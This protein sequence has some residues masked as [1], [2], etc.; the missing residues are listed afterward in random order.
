MYY[1]KI[2]LIHFIAIMIVL[3][4]TFFMGFYYYLVINHIYFL[5]TIIK[6]GKEVENMKE[7]IKRLNFKYQ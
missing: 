1:I 3:C 6:K 7:E 5:N 4:I 2:E